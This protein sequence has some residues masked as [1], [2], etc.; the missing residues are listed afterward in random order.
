MAL[1]ILGL[2]SV[3]RIQNNLT[4]PPNSKTVQNLPY[5]S[6]K[7][8]KTFESEFKYSLNYPNDWTVA[9]P[10][11]SDPTRFYN[12]GFDSPCNFDSGEIC[13]QMYI[14]SVPYGAD[15]I[16]GKGY[17]VIDPENKFS[18]DFYINPSDK[19]INKIDL[20]VGGEPAVGF[21]HFRSNYAGSTKWE[22]VVVFNHNNTRFTITYDELLIGNPNNTPLDW[23]HKN[24]FN[25][26]LST[27]KF[28][29]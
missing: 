27:F 23:Q 2:G 25:T 10:G 4:N 22:Y 8:W 3:L 29:E 14:S 20:N 19:V 28:K 12:P 24:I 11:E 18:P 13:S 15:R 1:V 21:E 9:A 26:I 6:T 7:D 16:L 5:L 17:P